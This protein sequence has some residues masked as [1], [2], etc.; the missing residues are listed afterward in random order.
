[1]AII[2]GQASNIQIRIENVSKTYGDHDVKALNCASL[3][4]VRGE[5]VALMGPSGCGKSTLLNLIAAIDKPTSGQIWLDD[6]EIS[7]LGDEAATKLRAGKIGFIF[8]FFNL[9][10][11]MTVLENVVLPLELAGMKEREAAAEAGKL[12]E[13]VG[14]SKRS[15]F[16]PSQLS[17]GEMQR[18]AI[19]RALVHKPQIILADEPTGNLDTENGQ[20]VLELLRST[21]KEF[22][23]T[24]VM[25]T[26]SDEA[27]S[28]ATRR[29]TMR[30][31]HVVSTGEV[32][33]SS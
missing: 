10:S 27:A 19:A 1:M 20:A 32:C 3:S 14:M 11:T 28:Y 13:R 7:S 24:I 17:G 33:S 4:L 6:Q 26:H 29:I 2:P 22:G 25:A 31:G 18:T 16:Y 30:D 9:L 8:Q 5:F 23:Q 12:L 15:Q 21:N